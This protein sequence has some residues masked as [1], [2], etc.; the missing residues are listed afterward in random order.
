MQ[1]PPLPTVVCGLVDDKGSS[2][3]S[4]PVTPSQEQAA[5]ALEIVASY[6]HGP[7]IPF[8]VEPQEYIIIGKLME[9]FRIKQSSELLSS[10]LRRVSEPAFASPKLETVGVLH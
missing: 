10:G 8:A 7:E 3:D 2:A 4:S 9:K 5:H 1:P 6:L